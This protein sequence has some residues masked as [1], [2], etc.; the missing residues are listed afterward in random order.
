[1]STSNSPSVNGLSASVTADGLR[2]S[3]LDFFRERDHSVVDSASLIPHDPSIMFT[4]PA[5][6]NMI[7]GS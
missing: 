6:V 2:S 7:D 3:F 1:M 4:M 5:T